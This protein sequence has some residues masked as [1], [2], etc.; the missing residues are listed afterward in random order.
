MATMKA[1][2]VLAKGESM[3]LV[4]IVVTNNTINKG[5]NTLYGY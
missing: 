3:I 2:Q 5:R 4:E 1:I